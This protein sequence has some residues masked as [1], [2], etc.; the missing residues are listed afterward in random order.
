MGS[1]ESSDVFH[2]DPTNG[3]PILSQKR[4]IMLVGNRMGLQVLQRLDMP[5]SGCPKLCCQATGMGCGKGCCA[6]GCTVFVAGIE[7][8]GRFMR[9]GS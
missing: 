2:L 7:I 3:H 4:P 8:D 6:N 1:T 9:I 5:I